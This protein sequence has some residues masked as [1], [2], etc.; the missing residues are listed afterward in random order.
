MILLVHSI[1]DVA[2]VNIAKFVLQHF[3]F[4]QNGKIF[5]ENPVYQAKING[6][7]VILV[8]LN[9]EAVEFQGLTDCFPNTE[10]AVFLSRHSSQSGTPTLSVHSPGNLDKA[11]LGGLPRQVSVAPA[12]AMQ[13]ALATLDQLKTERHLDYEVSYECTHHGPSILVP[14]MFVELGS[15]E[16]QWCDLVAA[17]V[18]ALAA[19]NAVAHFDSPDEGAALSIGIGGTHYNQKFTRMA[20]EGEATFGHMIP[21]YG[22]P[23]LDSEMILQ[24]KDRTHGK[25]ELAILDWKGIKGEDKAKLLAN[26]RE[27]GI[28]S[29]KV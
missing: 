19:I 2:G 9:Q 26:L 10:L 28:K 7:K 6:K 11:E 18:V 13:I 24:C 14:T 20:L 27:A 5:Q 12:K 29:T 8:S 22:V 25:V 21:K 17:E 23:S 15:T 16:R 3:P 1:L 4:T